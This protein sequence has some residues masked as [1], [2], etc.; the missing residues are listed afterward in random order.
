M[1]LRLHHAK[2]P[3]R[4]IA[5]ILAAAFAG[6]EELRRHHAIG[7]RRSAENADETNR[8]REQ[9]EARGCEQKVSHGRV[10]G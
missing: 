7:V 10:P 4:F 2:E 8:H 3:M 5:L 1:T 6:A 9:N